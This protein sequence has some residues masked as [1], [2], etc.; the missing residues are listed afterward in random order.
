MGQSTV[1]KGLASLR[2]ALG[3][4]ALVVVSV[5]LVASPRLDGEGVRDA[6]SPVATLA[7]G[8]L[9]TLATGKPIV[10]SLDSSHASEVAL[11]AVIRVG[12]SKDAFLSRFRDIARFKLGGPVLQIGK[13]GTPPRLADF[14]GLRLEAG[15]VDDLRKCRPG[16]CHFALTADAVGR[17]AREVDW[18]SPEAALQAERWVRR[19]LFELATAYLAKGN[20][21]LPVYATRR[22]PVDVA[23]NFTAIL[24]A[25]PP[26]LGFTPDVATY[27]REFPAGSLPDSEQFLY[28]SKENV[29]AKPIISLTHVV[30][31]LESTRGDRVAIASKQLYASHYLLASLGLTFIIDH[32]GAPEPEAHLVYLNRSRSDAL[33]GFLGPLRRSIV[34]NRARAGAEKTMLGMQRRLSSRP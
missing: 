34:R 28:W 27:L 30:I 20:D 14:D 3:A 29:G 24:E 12:V 10:K 2:P 31:H 33:V 5:G 19:W 23:A 22:P 32:L 1:G 21:A 17:V 15:D 8:D 4:L 26:L 11:L 18:S 16:D 13:L 25:S 9:Q 7:P 6:L